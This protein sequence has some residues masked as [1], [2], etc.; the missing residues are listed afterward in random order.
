MFGVASHQVDVF[1]FEP[2]GSHY[3]GRLCNFNRC[4]KGKR[5]CL[6]PGCGRQPFLKQIEGFHPYYDIVTPERMVLLFDRE[7]GLS[8]GA[9]NLPVTGG[10]DERCETRA[11]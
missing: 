4:P 6:V 9:A 5:E 11:I 2:G 8:R 10:G 1:L 7:R 3:H